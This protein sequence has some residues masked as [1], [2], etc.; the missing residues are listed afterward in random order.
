MDVR[1]ALT[2][3]FQI[4]SNNRDNVVANF[5]AAITRRAMIED[6]MQFSFVLN[7]CH[8]GEGT[9][10]CH[11]EGLLT[12]EGKNYKHRIVSTAFLV[13]IFFKELCIFR[14][15]ISQNYHPGYLLK[16]SIDKTLKTIAVCNQIYS[17]V[18]PDETP[19]FA[20]SVLQKFIPRLSTATNF[21]VRI[22][23]HRIGFSLRYVSLLLCSIYLRHDVFPHLMHK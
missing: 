18:V 20:I 15:F 21:I 14:S 2:Y 16:K 7:V 11:R 13:Y 4:F 5:I 19:G 22:S 23:Q 6:Y 8:V 1:F 9:N 3:M 10:F 12:D 17:T